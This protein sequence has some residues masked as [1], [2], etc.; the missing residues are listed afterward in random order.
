[1]NDE[2][3][4]VTGGVAV[5]PDGQAVPLSEDQAEAILAAAKEAEEARQVKIKQLARSLA[6]KRDEVV[7]AKR[8]IESRWIDDMRQYEGDSR[9]A[10]TK[11]QKSS[12]DTTH[13]APRIHVTRARTDLWEARLS[14]MLLPMQ[15]SAWDL[16]PDK[17]EYVQQDDQYQAASENACDKMKDAIECQLEYCNFNRSGRRMIRDACRIGTGVL[18]GPMNGIR[19][20]RKFDQGGVA[21]TETATPEIREADPWCF[22]P[23]MVPSIE[24]AEFAFYLH[25]MSKREVIEL[26]DFPGFDA[27]AIRTLLE[28]DPELG[29]VGMNIHHRNKGLDA[30]EPTTGRYA[31]W[32]YTGVLEKEEIEILELCGCDGEA[33]PLTQAMVDIWF[34]HDHVLKARVAPIEDDY[35]IPYYVFAPFPA[36]DTPFGYSLPYMC[37]DSARFADASYKIALHNLSVSSGLHVFMR[38]GVFKPADGN[39][40]IRGPKVWWIDDQK[41]GDRPL[42]QLMQVEIMPN[43][44][45]QAFAA[46]DKALAI[47]DLELNAEGWASQDGAEQVPTASGLA[48]LMNSKSIIQRRAASCADDDVFRPLIERMYWWN[49]Q[50]NDDPSIRGEFVVTT[51]AQSALLVK[52]VQVQH[53]MA[54]LQSVYGNPKF[55]PFVDDYEALESTAKLFE[56]PNRAKLLKTREEGEKAM[57]A[58]GQN[59]ELALIAAKTQT[60]QAKAE[61]MQIEAQIKQAEEQRKA[62]EAEE[63]QVFREADRQLDHEEEVAQYRARLLEAQVRRD[64]AMMREATARME[65]MQRMDLSAAELESKLEQARM[66]TQASLRMK[67]VEAGMKAK[68]MA[69]KSQFGSGI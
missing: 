43:V 35:R 10:D 25:L 42:G 27:D 41:D 18:M 58:Q 4:D 7:K 48:M 19:R 17:E 64:V 54:F 13:E 56:I 65:A 46:M 28:E 62:M 16:E 51:S 3:V 29:E 52:D 32:R 40:E 21:I 45:E 38:K 15:D 60:E 59:P 14:D 9:L 67:G 68:E 49:M 24:K 61:V 12:H 37:R 57:Q 22:F 66:Q 2:T 26:A 5:G 8:P 53:T 33:D 34:C 20:K 47:V 36:D 55:A 63:D 44:A 31:V 11:G 1:M 30:V 39:F 69:L 23:D 6:I 50:F